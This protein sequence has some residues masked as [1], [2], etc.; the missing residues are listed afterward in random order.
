MATGESLTDMMFVG[1]AAI[2][3]PPRPGVEAAVHSLLNSG[4]CVKMLTGDSKETA[5]AVGIVH[6][7]EIFSV[8]I[9]VCCCCSYY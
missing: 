2:S 1:L 8:S 9:G 6:I 7:T 4:V 3:D 5:I